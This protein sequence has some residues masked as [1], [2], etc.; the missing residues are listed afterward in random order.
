MQDAAGRPAPDVELPAH[1]RNPGDR[2]LR[3][4]LGQTGVEVPF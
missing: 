2:K 1:M 3:A 4:L